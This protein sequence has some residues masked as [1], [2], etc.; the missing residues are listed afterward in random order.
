M[1]TEE[2][3][4]ESVAIGTAAE[5]IVYDYL[6]KNNGQV[7]DLRKQKHDSFTG[8]RLRGTEGSTVLPDFFVHNKSPEKGNFALDV[9]F[10][11]SV[12]TINGKKCFTVDNKYEDYLR[13]VQIYRL[14]HL[15]IVFMYEG[16]MHF[17]TNA[18]CFDKTMF[19]N[20]YGSGWVYLFEYDKRRIQ[21]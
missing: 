6:I 7:Q 5:D 9:K 19:P 16:R 17:Y 14:D 10:K 11:S 18:D 12:Y 15:K 21:F 13:V 1:A 3:F 20:Q 2:E 4:R 8:P